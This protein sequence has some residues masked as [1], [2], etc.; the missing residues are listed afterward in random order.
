MSSFACYAGGTDDGGGGEEGDDGE[1]AAGDQDPE[2]AAAAKRSKA[3]ASEARES[4]TLA[5]PDSIKMK[6]LDR[7][8][9]V[10]PLFHHMA[11]MFDKGGAQGLLL[12]NRSV[13]GGSCIM[14]D[15]HEVPEQC[16]VAEAEADEWV[17]GVQAL[18]NSWECAGF[19]QIVGQRSS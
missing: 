6:P 15:P 9:E 2:A 11:A 4:D 13:Y 8:F 5:D 3:R 19:L 16:F 17:R 10:D 1:A 7:T 14:V 18:N 12:L